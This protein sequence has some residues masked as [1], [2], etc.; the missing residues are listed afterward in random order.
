M[1]II[2]NAFESVDRT[3]FLN[4]AN[5]EM[6][7]IDKALPIGYGQT[8]SQPSTVKRMLSLL[9]IKSGDK[10]M[11]V[12]SG[13]GWTTAL[14]AHLVGSAGRVYAVEKI[15]ELLKF[16]EENCKR[17]GIKNADFFL[18]GEKPGLENFAPYGRILVSAA[19]RELP[20][21]LL[22]QMEVG[23]KMVIPV[24]NS[25]FSIDRLGI[26][27]YRSTGYSGFRFVPLV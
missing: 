7:F 12:G 13:S 25:I 27:R 10:V 8:N 15:P 9:D 11:D 17:V 22:K 14:L 4:P 1:N 24:R 3:N 20:N 5:R 16:G 26:N 23:G 21:D 18:A 6:H 19:A 2:E